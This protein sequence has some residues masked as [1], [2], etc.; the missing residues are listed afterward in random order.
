VYAGRM[1]ETG[2]YQGYKMRSYWVSSTW[3]LRLLSSSDVLQHVA[4]G[5]QDSNEAYNSECEVRDYILRSMNLPQSIGIHP[6]NSIQQHYVRSWAMLLLLQ[7]SIIQKCCTR[8]FGELLIYL[9]MIQLIQHAS[10]FSAF[11][12]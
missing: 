5:V 4:N 8:F 11:L 12:P 1:K 6:E 3:I 9:Y 2:S 10:C 7:S